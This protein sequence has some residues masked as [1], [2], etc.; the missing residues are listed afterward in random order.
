MNFSDLSEI[1]VKAGMAS[2]VIIQN[3][4]EVF[5]LNLMDRDYRN[6]NDHTVYFIDTKQIGMGT[7]VPDC[8]L[9]FDE[10]PEYKRKDL[11][12]AARIRS[13]SI[14]AAFRFVK[15]QLD[16]R[17]RRSRNMSIPYPGW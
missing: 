16:E 3:D 7:S 10:M 4:C 1:L 17:P 13:D 9:Y 6:F 11:V 12:N 15:T 14:A 5:D 8:L 2:D